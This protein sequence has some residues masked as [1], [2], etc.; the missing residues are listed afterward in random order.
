[1]FSIV[2]ALK[3]LSVVDTERWVRVTALM[4][5]GGI[6]ALEKLWNDSNETGL[7]VDPTQLFIALDSYRYGRNGK[8]TIRRDLDQSQEAIVFPASGITD[9]SL[10]DVTLSSKL[11]LHPICAHK[12]LRTGVHLDMSNPVILN[13]QNL[14]L[15]DYITFLRDARNFF[16]HHNRYPISEGAF[17]NY[18]A[19]ILKIL[20]G[21]LNYDVNR[22]KDLKEAVIGAGK[23]STA[24]LYAKMDCFHSDYKVTMN[25]LVP[26]ITKQVSGA[27][28]KLKKQLLQFNSKLDDVA[29][30]I[31]QLVQDSKL[32]LHNQTT[33]LQ[34]QQA[35]FKAMS[36]QLDDLKPYVKVKDPRPLNGKLIKYDMIFQFLRYIL[37]G[38]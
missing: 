17:D 6:D 26:H 12:I 36:K 11:L 37:K 19:T 14:H 29:D 32:L 3:P 1:M 33:L 21:I 15:G 31:N 18:W 4:H 5:Y 16:M 10:F 9:V 25:A 7:P 38:I 24:F 22:V 27:A 23:F 2:G 13:S 34:N 35:H 28:D 30:N 20:K 8:G